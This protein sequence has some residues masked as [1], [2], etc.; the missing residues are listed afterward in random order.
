LTGVAHTH[1]EQVTLLRQLC[2]QIIVQDR[3]QSLTISH[4]EFTAGHTGVTQNRPR[5]IID[6]PLR[7]IGGPVIN[8]IDDYRLS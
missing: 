1:G 6:A 8:T 4:D 7:Y 3:H 5:I 2:G